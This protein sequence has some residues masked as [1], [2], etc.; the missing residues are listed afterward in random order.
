M[1]KELS[2]YVFVQITKLINAREINNRGFT[3]FSFTYKRLI[4]KY[5][6]RSLK[7]KGIPCLRQHQCENS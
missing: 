7:G 6:W 3:W 2:K 1:K 4:T 5:L